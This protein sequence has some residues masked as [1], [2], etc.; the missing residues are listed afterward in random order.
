[1]ACEEVSKAAKKYSFQVNTSEIIKAAI[2][3]GRAIGKII[4]IKAFHNER[5]STRAAYSNSTGI[6]PNWSRIIHIT[7]GKTV[8]V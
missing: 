8:K 6:D 7:I 1:M 3:P 5:P 4:V 2:I